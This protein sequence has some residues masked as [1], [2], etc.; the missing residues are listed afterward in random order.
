M[1]KCVSAVFAVGMLGGQ[2]AY[3]A[4]QI[5]WIDR[6][7]LEN[8]IPPPPVRGSQTEKNEIDEIL[9]ARAMATREQLIAARRDNDTE[10]PTI[11]DSVLGPK[12]NLRRLPKTKF[13]MD[14][15]MDVDR[16]DSVTT[17]HFFRRARPWIVDARVQTCAPHDS[18]PALNSYPSGHTML[19]F[20]LAVVLAS[21]MP[22]RAQA[23]LQ[24]ASQYGENRIVCGFH[25]RSDVSAGEQF[26][27]VLA[28]E[29]LKNPVFQGWFKEAKEELRT[30]GLTH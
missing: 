17:K 12:W 18:G 21:L 3:A 4:A 23:L 25:F 16:V 5:E 28:V 6:I 30:A 15:V 10:N 20:E 8:I 22:E 26:G 11:F 2:V 24:R 29:M 27:T 14:R 7:P 9:R 1:R 19:G 13:L